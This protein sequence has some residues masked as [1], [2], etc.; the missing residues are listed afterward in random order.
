V[1]DV[2]VSQS[3]SAGDQ[4]TQVGL[5][6]D[7]CDP[8]STGNTED[9]DQS[10]ETGD[11]N[12]ADDTN[13]G[14]GEGSSSES[15][16]STTDETSTSVANAGLLPPAI[17][18]LL[19]NPASPQTDAADEF[20]ELYNPNQVAFSLGGYRLQVGTSSTRTYTF[21]VG[22]QLA[23]GTYTAFFSAN[24]SLSL[25]NSGSR[26]KLLGPT[27]TVM[28]ASDPYGTAKDNQAWVIVGGKWQW[29]LTPTPNAPNTLTAVAS[30]A[31]K[32]ATAK[33]AIAKAKTTAATKTKTTKAKPVSTGTAAL[34][35]DT[36]TA[37][38]P[39]HPAVL[40]VI[41]AAAVLYGAYEYR[42]DVANYFRRLR[43]HRAAGREN[44]QAAEGR[45]NN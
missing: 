16:D 9:E 35:A 12:T 7:E 14:D 22:V 18:E 3:G 1:N 20:I 19:P 26:V 39:V 24:T 17:T 2:A 6:T 15:N 43:K 44:R 31:A 41:G 29:T 42:Q 8:T 36:A 4:Q 27:G 45:R 23:A 40:A 30:A 33:K 11:Q 10:G 13:T 25:N 5:P 21:P 34:V 32:A 28:S 37:R 38:S